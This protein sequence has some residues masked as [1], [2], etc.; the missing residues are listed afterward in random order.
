MTRHWGRKWEGRKKALGL[1][2]WLWGKNQVFK[3]IKREEKR[4]K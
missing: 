1:S 2:Q 4:G 3:L